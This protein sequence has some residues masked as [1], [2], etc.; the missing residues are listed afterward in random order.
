MAHTHYDR[1][2]ALDGTFLAIEDPNAHMHVGAIVVFERSPLAKPDGALDFERLRAFLEAS[3]HTMPRFRQ[4]CVEVPWVDERVWIDDERFNLDY[5]M[6]HTALPPPGE[7]RQLKRLAGRILS[8]KLDHHKPLWEMWIVEG[9][10]GDRFGMILKAHHA[11][12]DGVGGMDLFASLL[13][14]EPSDEIPPVPAWY[15]RRAPT[16]SKLVVDEIGRRAAMPFS[17]LDAAR[18]ALSR[19]AERLREARES[20][21]ALGD[22]IGAGLGA[23][24]ATA[25]NDEL[26]PYRRF[27]WTDTD[28]ASIR[29]VRKHL[30]G[31]LNDVVLATVAGAVGRFLRRRGE[32]IDEETV[33]RAMVPVSLRKSTE[34]GKPGNRVVNF[35]AQ[36]PVEERD[37]KRRLARTMETMQRLKESRLVKGAEVLEEIGDSGFNNLLIQFVRLAANQRSYNIVVT[38]VP[39]PPLPLYLLTSRMEVIYPVVPLFKNQCV[40]IALFTYNGRVHWGFNADWD[41]LPDLHYLVEDIDASFAELL[42]ASDAAQAGPETDS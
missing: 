30:G 20:I 22:T 36:L 24:T 40:G 32:S 4:R 29:E 26:G 7:T 16:T 33:F 10:E 31:T 21:Y 2:T 34:R 27:D 23:T 12:V 9:L 37:P 28:I 17:A 39:G 1:L 6:R 13:R 11:M 35:L 41:A 15:P 5:H 8:Q 42:E 19:P 3:L 38:N 18:E 25:L 14:L